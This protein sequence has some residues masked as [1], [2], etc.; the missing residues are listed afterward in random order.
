M[1]IRVKHAPSAAAIG[2]TAYTIGRGQRQERDIR[3]AVETGLRQTSLSLQARS[4]GA[5]AEARAGQLALGYEQL[6]SREGREQA[7]LEFRKHQ[8]QDE[9]A[10]QL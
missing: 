1:A 5:Q 3:F 8:Q 7:E 2:E 4:I 6:E 10:R 9:P